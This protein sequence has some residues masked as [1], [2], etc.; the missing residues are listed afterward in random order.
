MK[1]LLFMLLMA[2]VA[3][4]FTACSSSDDAP[5]NPVS[6]INCPSSAKIGS[7][8]T[9]QGTGF[10]TSG[11]ALYLT[12]ATSG[13]ETKVDAT[14]S[15]A[16]ATFTMPYT[17]TAGNTV[18]LTLKQGSN[19]WTIGTISVQ[20]ADNPITALS[21][22]EQLGYNAA[23]TATATISGVGFA[24]GD[25]VV[26][27]PAETDRAEATYTFPKATGTVTTD[28]LQITVPNI[29]EGEYTL[30]LVRG[31]SSWVITD[32]P[33]YVYQQK[34]IKSIE[35]ASPYAA[36]Y[37]LSSITLDFTYNTDGTLAAIASNYD[38]LNYTFAYSTGKVTVTIK[39]SG[40]TSDFTLVD[41]KITKNTDVNA[42]TTDEKYPDN[43]DNEWTYD[44]NGYL[45]AV[46]NNSQW[47]QGVNLK[48]ITYT[49][50]CMT[51]MELGGSMKFSYD[52]SIHAVPGTLDAAYLVN[53]FA[54]FL[55]K[56][57]AF[58]GL[59]ISQNL[60]V[61]KY[62]PSSITVQDIDWEKYEYVDTNITLTNSFA[63]NVLTIDSYGSDTTAG[64]YGST[65]K[66][67]YEN[68]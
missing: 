21:V 44:G 33:I 17:L 25:K 4:G 10:G 13:I 1:K 49:D 23:G 22:P 50:G 31:N 47:Y 2:C 34:Q 46:A 36:F 24:E 63:D 19:S 40:K 39:A 8:V 48:E 43:P 62:V 15:S 52:K 37:G 67:T 27:T 32:E 38:G 42:N 5:A 60:P 7:D 58:L 41:G 12:E 55:T 57:D 59:F 54:N 61:S 56:E 35:I 64:Y 29:T 28:G 45:T 11:I 9:V 14:Y 68:K 18:A 51:S 53:L 16:G 26:F 66:V 30:T 65:V 20:A 6:N 3:V